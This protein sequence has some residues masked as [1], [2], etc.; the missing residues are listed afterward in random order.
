MS[1]NFVKCL[2]FLVIKCYNL[3]VNLFFGENA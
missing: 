3:L 2:D 1:D